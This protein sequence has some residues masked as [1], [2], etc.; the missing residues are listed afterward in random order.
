MAHPMRQ[1]RHM[2]QRLNY[3]QANP[4]RVNSSGDG[5]A[6]ELLPRNAN[7]VEWP[8]VTRC[9][10]VT[11]TAAP[12]WRAVAPALRTTAWSPANDQPSCQL[13]MGLRPVLVSVTV[14]RKPPDHVATVW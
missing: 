2:W 7:V 10:P 14:A 4:F 8:G 13:A 1:R 12:S 6:S 5:L 9:F 3:P 11:V